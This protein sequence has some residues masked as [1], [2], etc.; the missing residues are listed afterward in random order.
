MTACAKVVDLLVDYLEGRLPPPAQANLERHL[1]ACPTC[2]AHVKTYRSTVALLRSLRD[3][4]LPPELRS[5]LRAFLDRGSS[6]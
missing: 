3:E 5:T 1:E 2:V 4:D 6:N